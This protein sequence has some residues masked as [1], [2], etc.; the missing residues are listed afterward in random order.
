MIQ[1]FAYAKYLGD[2]EIV[3]DDEGNVKG[4][5]GNPILLDESYEQDPV[6]LAIV[7]E[8]N[9]P[10]EEARNVSSVKRNSEQKKKLIYVATEKNMKY[11]QRED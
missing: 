8:M 10:I 5:Q 6:V 9:D 11:V 4:W 3:F 7:D 1:D 2:F